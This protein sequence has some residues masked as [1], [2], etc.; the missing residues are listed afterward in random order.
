M[1]KLH[2]LV[3]SLSFNSLK[4]D[5]YHLFQQEYFLRKTFAF[6]TV[7]RSWKSLIFHHFEIC[8]LFQTLFV[9]QNVNGGG[10]NVNIF[11]V[12]SVILF[13]RLNVDKKIVYLQ[14]KNQKLEHFERKKKSPW[15]FFSSLFN[16]KQHL[17]CLALL[18]CFWK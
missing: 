6:L 4:P 15:I 11:C 7:H 13:M 17:D 1:N 5:L 18:I 3:D 2:N 12:K 14:K 8:K 16:L 9:N 10:A